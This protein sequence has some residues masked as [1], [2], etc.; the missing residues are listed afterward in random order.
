MEG[1]SGR[2]EGG[3]ISGGDITVHGKRVAGWKRE[4]DP[5]AGVLRK[6]RHSLIRK[7]EG[8]CMV[9]CCGRRL[10][11]GLVGRPNPDI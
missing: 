3:M 8:A 1:G 4:E 6:G 10:G 2:R 5:M 9:W 11:L 7:Q